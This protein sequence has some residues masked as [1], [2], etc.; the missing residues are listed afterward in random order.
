MLPLYVCSGVCGC[1]AFVLFC[2]RVCVCLCGSCVGLCGVVCFR[3]DVDCP[4]KAKDPMKAF[5]E[6]TGG[7]EKRGERCVCACACGV[8]VGVWVCVSVVPCG[9]CGS[10][11][12][13]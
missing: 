10:V 13:W 9:L 6:L 3:L 8:C 7:R 1:C 4:V 5:K 12:V 11:Y 2:V